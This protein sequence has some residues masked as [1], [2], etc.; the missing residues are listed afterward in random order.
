MI[1]ESFREANGSQHYEKREGFM[2]EDWDL[3]SLS[4]GEAIV[5]LPTVSPFRFK[6]DLFV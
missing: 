2:V 3:A 5:G 4:V 6:F 1:L